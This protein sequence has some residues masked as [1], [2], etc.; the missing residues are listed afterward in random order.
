[1][2]NYFGDVP[3]MRQRQVLYKRLELNGAAFEVEFWYV[4]FRC[5]YNTELKSTAIQCNK[6]HFIDVN[7]KE[8]KNQRGSFRIFCIYNFSS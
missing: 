8:N 4:K 1:M 6:T 7:P 5:L 2:K 3:C